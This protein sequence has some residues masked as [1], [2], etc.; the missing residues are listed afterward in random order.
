MSVNL[1]PTPWK[2][3]DWSDASLNQI[4]EHMSEHLP[5][6]WEIDA[7]FENGWFGVVVNSP[8]DIHAVDDLID[9]PATATPAEQ[10]KCAFEIVILKCAVDEALRTGGGMTWMKGVP[11]EVQPQERK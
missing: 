5:E 4:A 10:L 1:P 3:E 11:M 2:N 9:E 6:G 7:T 8:T